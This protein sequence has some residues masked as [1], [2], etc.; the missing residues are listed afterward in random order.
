MK[1]SVIGVK[2]VS[3][4]YTVPILKEMVWS[5]KFLVY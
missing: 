2:K 1:G 3:N 4:K 5:T